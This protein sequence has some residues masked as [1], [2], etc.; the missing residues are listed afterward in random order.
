MRLIADIMKRFFSQVVATVLGF[1]I[2]FIL[3]MG[4]VIGIV[5]LSTRPSSP[6]RYEKTILHIALRGKVV[7]HTPRA[8]LQALE[9]GKK[10]LIDLIVLK[11]ALKRAVVFLMV[12]CQVTFELIKS[13]HTLQDTS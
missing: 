2:A 5:V 3:F 13:I 1:L 12:A 6:K 4:F 10:D 7:E 9:S 8:P 11:K